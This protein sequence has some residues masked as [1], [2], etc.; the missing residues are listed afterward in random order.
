MDGAVSEFVAAFS[1]PSKVGDPLDG[2]VIEQASFSQETFEA[3]NPRA[4][5]LAGELEAHLPG[6]DCPSCHELS[7]ERTW[8]QLLRLI[9]RSRGYARI[10]GYPFG[11][12]PDERADRSRQISPVTRREVFDYLR[13]DGRPWWGRMTE[14]AFL[15]RLYELDELPSTDR[16]YTT[17]ARDI[18]Q[19]RVT[20]YDWP[21]DWVFDDPRFELAGGPDE[22][23]LGFLAQVVHSVVQPNTERAAQNVSVLNSFLAADGWMLK[24]S[25]EM[26]GRPVYAPART[27]TGGVVAVSFAPG[28][29]GPARP[30]ADL[31]FARCRWRQ[32]GSGDRQQ[33]CQARDHGDRGH[34]DGGSRSAPQ[35]PAVIGD[36]AG[37]LD[38][39]SRDDLAAGCVRQKMLWDHG[40]GFPASNPEVIDPDSP[41]GQEWAQRLLLA[42]IEIL[43]PPDRHR[44]LSRPETDAAVIRDQHGKLRAAI[45]QRLPATG[46][47]AELILDH[48]IWVRTQDGTLYPAPKG[49]YWGLSWGYNG[50]GPGALAMLAGRLLSDIN[51]VAASSANGAPAGLWRLMNKRWAPG[52]ILTR[53]QLEAAHDEQ[54]DTG[55]DD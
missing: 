52:T 54:P 13:T 20:N 21:D 25:K 19:H 4:E 36:R 48:P 6:L 18:I 26:S 50:T 16:R 17:A 49:H 44:R 42:P 33:N 8:P 40:E 22:L 9:K 32:A 12:L 7:R 2:L 38:I 37:W 35:R 23:L 34:A 31:A 53:A 24:Q 11:D 10:V 14:V 29:G 47:L 3:V 1:N 45:S 28:T 46:P 39:L 5:R 55:H 51:A 15:G 30:G 43:G 41:H 27:G